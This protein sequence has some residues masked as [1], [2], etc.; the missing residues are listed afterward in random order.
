MPSATDT[1]LAVQRKRRQRR[2]RVVIVFCLCLFL[3]LSLLEKQV[4]QLGTVP[5]PISGNVLV[6][7]L[8]NT[9]VILLLLMVFLTMRNLAELVFD[10]RQQLIGATLRTKLVISFVS[11][12]L[13]PTTLLFFIAL[14]FVSSSMDYWFNSNVEESLEESLTIAKDVYQDARLQLVRQG[15]KVAAGAKRTFFRNDGMNARVEHIHQQLQGRK[16]DA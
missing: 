12:S 3:V 5:F 14:Q 16:A 8:I 1:E 9:N 2:I 10:R 4:F 6:F 13:I 15:G 7:A 11:L